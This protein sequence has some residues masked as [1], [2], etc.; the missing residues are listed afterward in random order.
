MRIVARTCAFAVL[1]VGLALSQKVTVE[2]DEGRDFSDYKTFHIVD[3]TLHSKNPSLNNE[4]VKRNLERSIRDRLTARGLTETD[5]R[6]DLNV[7]FSLGS[8]KRTEVDA[9]PAGWRGT[10]LVRTSFAEG[11]LVIDLRDPRRK[12]LVWRAISV[13]EKRD[14]LQLK[15]HLDDMVRKAVEKYPPKRK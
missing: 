15:D 14:P 2:F 13:E 6:P 1:T 9:Y 7:R 12:E 5:T 3:G 8:G 10:R 11:T 4:I